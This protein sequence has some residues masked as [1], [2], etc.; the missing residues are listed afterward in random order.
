[1][2][3]DGAKKDWRL[4]A[5]ALCCNAYC[6][7]PPAS[8]ATSEFSQCV[9]FGCDAACLPVPARIPRTCGACWLTAYPRPRKHAPIRIHMM[10][11]WFKW[12][13]R[14]GCYRALGDLQT[15]GGDERQFHKLKADKILVCGCCLGPVAARNCYCTNHPSLLCADEGSSC[16]C[17]AADAA[18]PCA[19]R[20]PRTCGAL[21]L[22][23]LPTVACCA[24]LAEV[25][26][27]TAF[28]D[29]LLV[30]TAMP[31]ELASAPE[32]ER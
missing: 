22:V 9:C 19:D 6:V 32:M 10:G 18:L 21:G 15:G 24:P 13:Q 28:E 16:C 2:A 25:I 30:A 14:L 3:V 31:E 5:G 8:C 17:C 7:W 11:E 1:M 26:G 27:E 20:V 29:S 4:C 12:W 23:C